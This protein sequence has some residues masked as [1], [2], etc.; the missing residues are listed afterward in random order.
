MLLQPR[1]E[2]CR[3][4]GILGSTFVLGPRPRVLGFRALGCRLRAWLLW[5]SLGFGVSGF[6]VSEDDDATLCAAAWEWREGCEG[7]ACGVETH[8]NLPTSGFRE[9]AE[10][11]L[12]QGCE[13]RRPVS[14]RGDSRVV[15]NADICGLPAAFDKV[16]SETPGHVLER[17]TL[18]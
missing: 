7:L 6:R 5:F 13:G 17:R 10:G 14:G 2:E 11:F 12:L 16:L 9:G 8:S 4:S 1:P 15:D 18:F 3:A